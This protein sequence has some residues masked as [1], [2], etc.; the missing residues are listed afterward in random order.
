MLTSCPWNQKDTNIN[1][2]EDQVDERKK[3]PR[4]VV[5]FVA[6]QRIFLEVHLAVHSDQCPLDPVRHVRRFKSVS[7]GDLFLSGERL[8]LI[9]DVAVDDGERILDQGH[10]D[11][12]DAEDHPDVDGHDIG[13][14]DLGA[15]LRLLHDEGEERGDDERYSS[16]VPTG[17]DPEADERRDH[18]QETG[19]VYPDDVVA[20]ITKQLQMGRDA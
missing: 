15:D 20:D 6:I 8:L 14:I 9:H 11:E 4:T 19:A 13:D 2:D 3:N 12:E 10:E 1:D 7:E 18:Q 17:W 5:D 16:R